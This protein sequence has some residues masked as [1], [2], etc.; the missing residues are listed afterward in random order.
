[1]AASVSIPME[2]LLEFGGMLAM[3]I[4]QLSSDAS[5]GV[6]VSGA[7]LEPWRIGLMRMAADE[8]RNEWDTNHEELVGSLANLFTSVQTAFDNWA[9]ADDRLGTDFTAAVQNVMQDAADRGHLMFPSTEGLTGE[10]VND[11]DDSY[12]NAEK[13]PG[14]DEL[15]DRYGDPPAMH[16]GNSIQGR[17]TMDDYREMWERDQAAERDRV[18]GRE[19][20]RT[21]GEKVSD[22]VVD[23]VKEFL[24]DW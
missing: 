5:F 1:M 8:F 13:M 21:L 12:Y 2:G 19:D 16:S 22:N 10:C 24:L 18:L 7:I 17:Y 9:R 20:Q 14:Y 11:M 23:P 3:A 15:R 6:D 4:D